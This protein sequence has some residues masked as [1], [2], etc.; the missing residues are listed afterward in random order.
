MAG[1]TLPIELS[2]SIALPDGTGSAQTVVDPP[3]MVG[4]AQPGMSFVVQYISIFARVPQGQAVQ[5][6]INGGN[7]GGHWF[8]MFPQGAFDGFDEYV[9][10][11]LASFVIAPAGLRTFAV[12]RSD[13][14][15]VGNVD[16]HFTG[17]F[18]N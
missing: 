14:A 10:S 9:C 16:V 12:T 5:C 13:T 18:S 4:P 1:S 6:M 8:A 11:Q 15:G 17:V 3:N 2:L 7:A